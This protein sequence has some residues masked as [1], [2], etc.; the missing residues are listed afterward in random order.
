M[1]IDTG[2]FAL[3]PVS[4]T[5]TSQVLKALDTLSNRYCVKFIK[6]HCD[7]H[8]SFTSNQLLL[9]LK[10]LG[11]KECSVTY[12]PKEASSLNPVERLH[13]EACSERGGVVL[14]SNH[15]QPNAFYSIGLQIGGKLVTLVAK[16][17]NILEMMGNSYGHADLFQQ[18]KIRGFPLVFVP[19]ESRRLKHHP[20]QELLEWSSFST[21]TK[22][23]IEAAG[24]HFFSYLSFS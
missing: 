7:L 24:R 8:S 4:N 12:S 6:I 3:I 2:M 5:C 17:F 11:H 19:D 16:N 18:L 20:E 1:C 15:I 22:Y 10:Q 21:A 23:K 14:C 9:G 13:K